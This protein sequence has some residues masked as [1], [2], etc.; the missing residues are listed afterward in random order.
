MVLKIYGYTA[1]D[2][3]IFRWGLNTILIYRILI[4]FFSIIKLL[5]T[6]Y[7]KYCNGSTPGNEFPPSKY[8]C[9]FH[10]LLLI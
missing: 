3:P 1:D 10:G 6:Y 8:F 4:V 5:L 9:I 2:C 7:V